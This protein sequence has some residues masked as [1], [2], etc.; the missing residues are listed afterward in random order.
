[1]ET[2]DGVM[3]NDDVKVEP[4]FPNSFV[5]EDHRH[6]ETLSMLR[7]DDGSVGTKFAITFKKLPIL[8]GKQ[9]AIGRVIKGLNV[10]NAINCHGS[11]LGLP[12]KTIFIKSCG[13]IE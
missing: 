4:I 8:I 9:V 13:M 5:S 10:L 6:H 12:K 1:M 7:N 3:S 11:K 2:G